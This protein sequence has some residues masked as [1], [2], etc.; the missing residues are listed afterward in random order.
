VELDLLNRETVEATVSLELGLRVTRRVEREMVVEA[1]V[2]PPAE[3]D[4][5]TLTFVL[6]REGDTLWKLARRYR[7]PEERILQANPGLAAGETLAAGR[8][9]CIPRKGWS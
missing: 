5:P 6:I 2:V 8:R 1:V 9:V 3:A 7:V 4:V